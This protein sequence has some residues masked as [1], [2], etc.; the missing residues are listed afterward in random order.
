MTVVTTK[1][2]IG[3]WLKFVLCEAVCISLCILELRMKPFILSPCSS[4]G[5]FVLVN[6]SVNLLDEDQQIPSNQCSMIQVET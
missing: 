1:C 3:Q 2:Q 6:N 5:F 4:K